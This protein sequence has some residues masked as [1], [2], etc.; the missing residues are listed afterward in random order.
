[1]VE[2]G[3]MKKSKK[4]NRRSQV[5]YPALDPKFNLKT[6]SDLI[7]A[8]YI[9]QLS[10]E[11]KDWLNRF[12]E[13]YVNANFGHKG[14]LIQ[15]RKAYRKDSYDRNNARNRD[16]LTREH[17][18]GHDVELR[19]NDAYSVEDDIIRKIDKDALLKKAK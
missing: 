11:E 5:K 19:E 8:D 7:E 16:I 13:E 1:M 2:S 15:R 9:D 4:Q 6:R 17:A 10:E 12:N 18:M 14:K 3:V